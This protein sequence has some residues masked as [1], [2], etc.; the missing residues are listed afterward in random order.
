MSVDMKKH[1][2]KIMRNYLIISAFTAVFGSVYEMFGHGV[3]SLFMIFAFAPTLILG[4]IP[5]GVITFI[6]IGAGIPQRAR[7]IYRVGVA[8][9]TLGMIFK[10]VLDIYG[11]TSPLTKFYFIASALMFSLS[12]IFSALVQPNK[13]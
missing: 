1:N 7:S 11:T 13:N 10:G 2:L 5:S 9:L 8:S 12:L 4:A 3:Y 6:G